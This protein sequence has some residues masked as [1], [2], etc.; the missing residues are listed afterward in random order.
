MGYQVQEAC[1]ALQIIAKI[2]PLVDD[3]VEV[4]DCLFIISASKIKTG[5]LVVKDEHAVNI[6]VA[7]VILQHLFQEGNHLHS[8][9]KCAMKEVQV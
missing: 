8:L 5:D 7:P 2:S 3:P 9:V 6:Q 4:I 1:I